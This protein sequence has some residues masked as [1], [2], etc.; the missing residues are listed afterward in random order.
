LKNELASLEELQTLDSETLKY[1]QE[2]SAIPEDLTAMRGDVAHVGEILEKEKEHLAEA[3]QWR[4]DREKGIVSQNQLLTKSKAKL[5]LARNEKESKAAQREIDTIRKTIQEREEETLKVMDAIEQYRVAIEK[6]SGGFAELEK[7]LADSEDAAKARMAV[8]EKT[9]GK[10]EA[11]RAEIVAKIPVK[12]LRLYDRISKR[13]GQ[14]VVEAT[15]G[16]CTGC[17]IDIL[18][19][20]YNELQRGDKLYQCPSCF[21]ILIYKGKT[22][23]DGATEE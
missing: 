23:D 7:Q 15:E 3:E 13:F 10:T 12:T 20:V 1:R 9:I 19:Q 4:L 17:N 2:A 5:Q 6:H 18:A 11:R 16:H 21:R 14:A 22:D 8:I